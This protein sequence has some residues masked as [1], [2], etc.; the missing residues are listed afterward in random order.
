[1]SAMKDVLWNFRITCNIFNL[2]P[3][4]LTQSW[5]FSIRIA[6]ATSWS[7]ASKES[8]SKLNQTVLFTQQQYSGADGEL[9]RHPHQSHCL[10]GFLCFLQRCCPQLAHLS[11]APCREGDAH[12]AGGRPGCE[13]SLQAHC[14]N[15]AAGRCAHGAKTLHE[16]NPAS[17]Q[18]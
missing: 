4:A 10:D 8:R 18:T 11:S 13:M 12:A 5:S 7:S 14:S 1:M 16:K 3:P 2:A 6:M 17:S 15:N 9:P